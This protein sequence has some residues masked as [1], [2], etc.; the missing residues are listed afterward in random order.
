[1]DNDNRSR[2]QLS[3]LADG[4]LHAHEFAAAMDYAHTAQA[5]VD[6]QVYHVIGDAMRGV[7][8][9]H[10]ADSQ[11]LERLRGQLAQEAPRPVVEGGVQQVGSAT[12]EAANAPFWKWAAGFASLVAAVGLAWTA[13]GQLD[14]SVPSSV[15]ATAPASAV[16]A[17]FSSQPVADGSGALMLRDPRLDELLAAHKRYGATVA[18]QM[19]AGFLRNA[20]F[21]APK[22]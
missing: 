9:A 20:S 17:T 21:D 15:L 2:E 11:L 13:W 22:R 16:P 14:R 19:P 18:L 5:Q 6:W 7:Q 1:M 10:V 8:A 4:E 3:A 12:Q